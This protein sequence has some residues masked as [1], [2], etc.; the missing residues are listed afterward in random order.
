MSAGIA[1]HRASSVDQGRLGVAKTVPREKS[2][3][4]VLTHVCFLENT[5]ALSR[6]FFIHMISKPISL[7]PGS[8]YCQGTTGQ[9]NEGLTQKRAVTLQS[10][11][12]PLSIQNWSSCLPL[13][14]I[15]LVG[16]L[17]SDF[18]VSCPEVDLDFKTLSLMHRMSMPPDPTS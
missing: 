2:W 10:Y 6:Q 4:L 14:L 5:F 8:F 15:H 12:F 7:G 17:S 13:D 1:V 18:S 9:G 11:Q 16:Q 3:L